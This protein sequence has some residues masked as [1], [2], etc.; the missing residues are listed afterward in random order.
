MTTAVDKLVIAI[1]G[2][3]PRSVYALERL[4]ALLENAAIRGQF[5]IHIFE[6]N[7]RYG[8]GVAHSDCQNGSSYLNRT[9]DQIAFAADESVTEATSL[10]PSPLRMTFLEWCQQHWRQSGDSIFNLQA[11]DVPRRYLHGMALREFFELYAA[12]LRQIDGISVTTHPEQVIGITRNG[13]GFRMITPQKPAGLVAHHILFIT[14]HTPCRPVAKST[15]ARFA[16]NFN[17]IPWAYPLEETFTERQIPAHDSIVLLGMGLTALDICLFLTEARGGTFMRQQ[18]GRLHYQPSGKEPHTITTLSRSGKVYATRPLNE[19]L[20][21]EQFHTGLFFTTSAVSFLRQH[22]GRTNF[23]HQDIRQPQLDFEQDLFPLIVL[24]MAWVY[25]RTLLGEQWLSRQLTAVNA[26][27]HTFLSAQAHRGEE[28]IGRLLAPLQQGFDDLVERLSRS[29]GGTVSTRPEDAEVACHIYRTL[30]DEIVDTIQAPIL[31]RALGPEKIRWQH[32]P[33]LVAHKFDWQA[34][35]YPFA[36]RPPHSSRQRKQQILIWL[37]KDL[38]AAR[39]GNI[40]N[41]VKACCDGVW[42]DLRTVFS[43]A[44]DFGGLTPASHKNFIQQWLPHY[45]RLSNG[46]SIEVMEKMEALVRQDIVVLPTAAKISSKTLG[47]TFILHYG[48]KKRRVNH[49]VCAR[50]HPFDARYQVNPLYPDMLAKGIIQLWVN[51]SSVTDFFIPGAVRIT[52]EFH[53]VMHDGTVD[54][55]L[56]FLGSPAEGACFFQ[57]TAARPAANSSVLSAMHHWAAELVGN[58]LSHQQETQPETFGEVRE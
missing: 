37:S 28:D 13:Q 39:Q 14:G 38:D 44:C 4:L 11:Q 25:Y 5:E 55:R 50:V 20:R 33:R 2:G 43:S 9:A 23:A 35:F 15:E 36:S 16:R 8:A 3:G 10:L 42:R 32:S 24:E 47:N 51:R 29:H 54:D 46:A 58:L 7:G 57:N 1:V 45:N 22:C 56:T 52:P 31:L 30:T 34:I 17:Y 40:R 6:P 26:T 48:G 12:K 53:P 19:K 21:P 49:V 18:S 27:Y 41:P